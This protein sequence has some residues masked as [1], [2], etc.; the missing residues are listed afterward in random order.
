MRGFLEKCKM[1]RENS[2]LIYDWKY[3]LVVSATFSFIFYL[4][5]LFSSW[6]YS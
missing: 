5:I 6:V 4:G 2:P 1:N 3:W